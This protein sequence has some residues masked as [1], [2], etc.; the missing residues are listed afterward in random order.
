MQEHQIETK[1][2]VES[3]HKESD[4]DDF[5]FDDDGQPITGKKEMVNYSLAYHLSIA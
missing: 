2:A 1:F 5:S 3:E 4:D